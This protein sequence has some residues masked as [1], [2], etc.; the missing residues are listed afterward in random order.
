MNFCLIDKFFEK[1]KEFEILYYNKGETK[2]LY[3]KDEFILECTKLNEISFEIILMFILKNWFF[4]E[5][6]LLRQFS[7][8]FLDNFFSK[9]D[10]FFEIRTQFFEDLLLII[11]KK[12]EIEISKER[13]IKSKY[14]IKE[15]LNLNDVWQ[16]VVCFV[17]LIQLNKFFSKNI[18]NYIDFLFENILN[19]IDVEIK[20]Y[21]TTEI[22]DSKLG[23][24]ICGLI[25]LKY[26]IPFF[27]IEKHKIIYKKLKKLLHSINN[28]SF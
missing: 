21:Q 15:N 25:L 27:K 9:A 10:K 22:L 12:D 13:K 5:N 3:W 4:S 16:S 2:E 17:K 14:L 19:Y 28:H 24:C 18:Y 20:N 7:L 26:L 11:F 1:K 23:Y 6:I 8:K